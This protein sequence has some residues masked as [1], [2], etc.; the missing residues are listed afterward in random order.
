MDEA[1]I[2]GGVESSNWVWASW[3]TVQQTASLESLSSISSTLTNSAPPVKIGVHFTAGNIVLSGTGGPDS[4]TFYVI[5][6]TNLTLPLTQ[7]QVLSTNTFDGSG[8]FNVS[9]PVEATKPAEFIQIK[10]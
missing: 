8:D 4:G 5:G 2:H 3:M 6:S 1:R 9:I 7:W 10:E